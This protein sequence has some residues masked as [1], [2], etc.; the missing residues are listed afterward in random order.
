[1]Y[2]LGVKKSGFGTPEGVEP[3]KVHRGELLQYLLGY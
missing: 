1:L 2:L 3:E